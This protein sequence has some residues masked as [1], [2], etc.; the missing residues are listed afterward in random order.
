MLGCFT[1]I[2]TVI[3]IVIY[4]VIYTVIYIVIHIDFFRAFFEILAAMR[5][6]RR[7]LPLFSS[8]ASHMP[9]YG[10]QIPALILSACAPRL[11]F[12]S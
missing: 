12:R 6:K 2:Y 9:S 1:L 10:Q 3:Y 4:I 5:Q 7:G 11:H 8:G